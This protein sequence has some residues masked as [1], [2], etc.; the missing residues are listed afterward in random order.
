MIAIKNQKTKTFDIFRQ[1]TESMTMHGFPNIFRTKHI[2]F[3]IMWTIF[4][5]SSNAFCFFIISRILINFFKYDI[6][7]TIKVVEKDSM[8]FPAVTVC[9]ANPFVTEESLNYVSSFLQ[10]NNLT[11]F[12][13]LNLDSS[14]NQN[15]SRLLYNFILVRY[16]AVL[17]SKANT[18]DLKEK[19]FVPFEK[20]FINCLYNLQSCNENDWQWYYDYY[21]GNCYR[22]NSGRNTKGEKTQIKFTN[23]A[24]AYNGLM[25]E[26]FVGMPNSQKTLSTTKGARIFIDEYKFNP[27]VERGY[28]IAPSYSTNLAIEKIVS[29]SMP[30]PYSDCVEDLDTIDSFDSEYYR[31]VLRSNLTYRQAEC[32]DAFIAAESFKK[33]KCD[34][35]GNSLV[36]E[37]NNPCDTLEEQSCSFSVFLELIESNFKSRIKSVCPLE[38]ESVRY[39]VVKSED[40]YPSESYANDLLKMEKI[41]SLFSN[42]SNV[43]YEELSSDI[44]AVNVYFE[45]MEQTE[46]KQSASVT[47]DGLVGSIGGTLGLFL[48]ISVLSF[49]EFID[50]FFQII[51]SKKS[52]K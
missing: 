26:L 19:L 11:N 24:G 44:L 39:K 45:Y 29:K 15:L 33:C 23:N 6:V 41:K 40:R 2:T 7:T 10:I 48:G 20:M 52:N 43:T 35:V 1:W 4:F 36:F 14:Q 13:H 46:I 3:K 28:A 31:K 17:F 51:F 9:N 49:A 27:R 42:R 16:W 30:R 25:L 47:W 34:E 38:C 12:T 50:L 37:N 32:F 21:H 8:P 5:L 18:K 22:F